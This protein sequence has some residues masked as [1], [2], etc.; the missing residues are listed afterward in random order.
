MWT[1]AVAGCVADAD[2]PLGQICDGGR[3]S[4]MVAMVNVPQISGRVTMVNV[5]L[6]I[7]SAIT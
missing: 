3:V 1:M 2:C 7:G 5:F 4:K 6:T